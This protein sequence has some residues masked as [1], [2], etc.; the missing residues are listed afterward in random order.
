[1]F[2]APNAYV[3]FAMAIF[4]GHLWGLIFLRIAPYINGIVKEEMRATGQACWSVMLMGLGPVIGSALGGLIT[5][6]FDIRQVFL[7]TAFLLLITTVAFFFLFRRRR[8][9]DRAEGFT[10]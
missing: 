7:L 2:I 1:M 10:G 4:H 6:R 9:A 8:A 5:I 3:M